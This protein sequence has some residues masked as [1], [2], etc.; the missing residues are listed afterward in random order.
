[1]LEYLK[2][3]FSGPENKLGP[4]AFNVWSTETYT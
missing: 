1:M 4:F 3:K 2:S